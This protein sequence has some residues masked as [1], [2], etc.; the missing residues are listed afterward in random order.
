M[1]NSLQDGFLLFEFKSSDHIE[2]EI[3]VDRMNA[4]KKAVNANR[5]VKVVNGYFKRTNEG[6]VL[7]C[8]GKEG[9]QPTI[10]HPWKVTAAGGEVVNVRTG[11]CQGDSV[12]IWSQGS[13]TWM[14]YWNGMDYPMVIPG[15]GDRIGWVTL[16]VEWNAYGQI[17]AARVIWLLRTLLKL[18]P[19]EYNQDARIG[20]TGT[21]SRQGY[22]YPSS[23]NGIIHLPLAYVE[24][25]IDSSSQ[26]SVKTIEQMAFHNVYSTVSPNNR[27]WFMGV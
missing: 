26:Y 11:S 25:G 27:G 15:G 24:V 12:V 14:D 1:D 23:Q 5:V 9:K 20:A 22:G 2:D 13:G 16:Q 18:S 8:G 19:G 21:S 4:I 10:N 7:V 3:T 6:I 17:L